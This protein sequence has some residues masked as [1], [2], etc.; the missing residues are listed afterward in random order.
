M[1]TKSAVVANVN[2]SQ[3]G[4]SEGDIAEFI[5]KGNLSGSNVNDTLEKTTRNH[6][7]LMTEDKSLFGASNQ[8]T[9][10]S[11]SKVFKSDAEARKIMNIFAKRKTAIKSKRAAPGASQTRL[12]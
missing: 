10:H 9:R 5:R 3:S 11:Y 1:S 4:Y 2:E 6:N 8:K 7:V 12:L